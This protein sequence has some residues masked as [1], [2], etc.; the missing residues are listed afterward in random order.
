MNDLRRKTIHDRQDDDCAE[1]F[2]D[3][4]QHKAGLT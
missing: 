2:S 1:Y 4:L 3:N